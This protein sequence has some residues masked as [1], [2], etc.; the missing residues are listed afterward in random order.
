LGTSSNGGVLHGI[1]VASSKAGDISYI[2]PAS[3]IV[4]DVK[5]SWG[6]ELPPA[7]PT[8]PTEK[9]ETSMDQVQTDIA[10]SL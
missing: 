10:V 2:L 1:I 4:E 5:A 8:L 7:D 3:S 9:M 6:V